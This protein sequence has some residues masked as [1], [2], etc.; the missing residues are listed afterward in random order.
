MLA[1]LPALAPVGSSTAQIWW[2]IFL[3]G[4]CLWSLGCNSVW[5]PSKKRPD[6]AQYCLRREI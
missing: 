4:P 1:K 3:R 5:E 6:N 2:A